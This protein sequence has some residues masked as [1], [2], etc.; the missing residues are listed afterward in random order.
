MT[1]QQ[2]IDRLGGARHLIEHYDITSDD[3]TAAVAACIEAA[4]QDAKIGAELR[5]IA[6]AV[7]HIQDALRGRQPQSETHALVCAGYA[8]IGGDRWDVEHAL[9]LIGQAM[10]PLAAVVALAMGIDPTG[11]YP[12]RRL[13]RVSAFAA[14]RASA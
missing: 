1:G 2:L 13:R 14:D 9:D 3:A 12:V 11:D 5:V 8:L 6:D 4:M 10:D 7:G